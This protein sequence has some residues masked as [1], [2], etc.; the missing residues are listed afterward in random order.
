MKSRLCGNSE[1]KRASGRLS[2]DCRQPAL[3]DWLLVN[4][5]VSM[6]RR[7][8]KV[9]VQLLESQRLKSLTSVESNGTLPWLGFDGSQPTDRF[10]RGSAVGSGY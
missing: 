8:T 7:N 1:P 3:V 5:V 10:S 4:A 2:E 6:G 9:K